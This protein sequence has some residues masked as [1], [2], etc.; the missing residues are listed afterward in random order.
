MA[1]SRGRGDARTTRGRSGQQSGS[2]RP[3]TTGGSARPAPKKGDIP[4]KGT[5][6]AGAPRRGQPAKG[7]GM[8]PKP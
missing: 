7:E 3:G 2:G 4:A 5:R 1:E 8:E 6:Q